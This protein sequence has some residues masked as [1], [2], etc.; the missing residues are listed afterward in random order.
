MTQIELTRLKR[1]CVARGGILFGRYEAL[2]RSASSSRSGRFV[3][4]RS[5]GNLGRRSR[6]RS[7]PADR[8]RSPSADTNARRIDPH[9]R[10][11]R[12]ARRCQR[13][14]RIQGRRDLVEAAAAKGGR[15]VGSDHSI[16]LK[17]IVDQRFCS[18]EVV[19]V[20]PFR[21]P[22]VDRREKLARFLASGVGLPQPGEARGGTK[23]Q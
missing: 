19:C 11:S 16:R 13:F 4:L 23:F 17:Q 2:A 22:F 12:R 14:R 1:F 15:S 18:F 6:G 7:T 9:R 5:T 10:R 8:Q 20:E 21:E 3:Q